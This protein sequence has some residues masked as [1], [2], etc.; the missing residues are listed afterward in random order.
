MFFL[1]LR[2]A[3]RLV[4][5]VTVDSSLGKAGCMEFLDTWLCASQV[6][7][8]GIKVLKA[9]RCAITIKYGIAPEICLANKVKSQLCTH[10]LSI[11]GY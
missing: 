2:C 5:G 3:G 7:V 6:G 10:N 9:I 1:D 4:T 8:H 11:P